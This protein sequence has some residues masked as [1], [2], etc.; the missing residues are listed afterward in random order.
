MYES[1]LVE[2]P[3]IRVQNTF[4]SVLKDNWKKKSHV[5]RVIIFLKM[6]DLTWLLKCIFF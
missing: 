4:T 6:S 5:T 3:N 1:C 2:N